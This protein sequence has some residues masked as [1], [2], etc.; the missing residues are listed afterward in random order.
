M[1][2]KSAKG[3]SE[4]KYKAEP[5]FQRHAGKLSASVGKFSPAEMPGILKEPSRAK[6][7]HVVA[8][9]ELARLCPAVLQ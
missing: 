7:A 9:G 2:P 5:F 4:T 8:A 1:I 6:Q 3:D